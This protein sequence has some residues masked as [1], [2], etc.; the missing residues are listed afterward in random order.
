MKSPLENKRVL[1]GVTGSI[2]CYKAADLASKLRQAGA[3]VDVVLTEA[4]TQ[5][6]TPLTFQSV[7]GRRAYVDADLWGAEGHVLHIGLGQAA[8][9]LVIAPATA[10]TM[11][12]LAHGQGGDLLS[13]TALTANCP[14]LIAPA[15]DGGMWSHPA[16][17]A[18]LEV[19]N[20]RGAIIVGPTEGHLAS[21][22][23]AIGRM[24]EPA[25]LLGH[26]RYTLAQGGAL[27]GR[28]VVVTTGGTREAID[29]VRFIANRSSGKQGYALAQAALDLGGEVTLI[30]SIT[31][32]TAPIGAQLV[33]VESASQMLEA[34]LEAVKDAD[35]LIMAAAVADFRPTQV[36]DHKIKKSEQTPQVTLTLNP[37]ILLQV[38]EQ[39]GSRGRPEV[40][41]G[42][43]A[44]SQDLLENA[45]NKLAAKKLDLIVAN[46]I[47]ASDAGFSTDTNRVTLLYADG[48]REELPLMLKM[49]VAQIVL[50]GAVALLPEGG[51]K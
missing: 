50:A 16:T 10:H 14:L 47:T 49:E 45:Q 18:N 12:K 40:V 17:Q 25:E 20:A 26:I 24:V 48:R 35:L 9:L 39:R 3:E 2:A 51:R 28:K 22:L 11:A 29:P 32:L 37:D 31:T 8:D 13:L 19:L 1:L 38:A 27:H 4:A 44:E 36:A 34:V 7:T 43:A 42:F 23:V 46:D 5:F 41:V 30:S 33:E 15:M 21:G 6:V